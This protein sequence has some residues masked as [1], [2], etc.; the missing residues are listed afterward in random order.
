MHAL[1]GHIAENFRRV[2][3]QIDHVRTDQRRSFWE[4]TITQAE[5][6]IASE[7]SG[8]STAGFVRRQVE[9][10]PIK[11]PFR[12]ESP[13]YG[14]AEQFEVVAVGDL[15]RLCCIRKRQVTGRTDLFVT[16]LRGTPQ[17]FE[18]EVD[19][20]E[21]IRAQSNVRSKAKHGVPRGCDQRYLYRSCFNPRDCAFKGLVSNPA[22]LKSYEGSRK[23]VS[24][25][26]KGLTCS[27]RLG[28]PFHEHPEQIAIAKGP[29]QSKGIAGGEDGQ[30]HICA[31]QHGNLPNQ[32][33]A[34]YMPFPRDRSG[35]ISAT[36]P[37]PTTS[38]DLDR[39]SE[40][41][42]SFSSDASRS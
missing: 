10:R 38:S 5:F 8:E 6:G 34:A 30:R 4:L 16:A 40:P 18:L 33:T 41:M 20:A 7:S 39:S 27:Q 23:N 19:K 32:R 12:Q 25:T 22:R 29:R 9:P 24:P 36:R 31:D 21:I 37:Y 3:N 1:H 35:L 15:E 13:R 26:S 42:Y 17:P 11:Q 28:R 14:K 2:R